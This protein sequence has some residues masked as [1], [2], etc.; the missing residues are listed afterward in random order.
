MAPIFAD[1]IGD[2]VTSNVAE[3]SECATGCAMRV[4]PGPPSGRSL[5]NTDGDVGTT[6][7][8]LLFSGPGAENLSDAQILSRIMDGEGA[9]EEFLTNNSIGASVDFDGMSVVEPPVAAPLSA[10]KSK[11]GKKGKEGGKS[12]KKKKT[13]FGK[14]SK[15]KFK[16]SKSK[17]KGKGN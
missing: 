16:S 9:I 5:Q 11:S 12:A 8:V 13:F 4:S 1:V 3:V 17:K 2:G 6:N 7:F 14:S 10:K 15:K